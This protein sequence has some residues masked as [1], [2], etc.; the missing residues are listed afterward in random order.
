MKTNS[1]NFYFS[2][3]R[4]WKHINP[5]RRVQ[6][7][8]VFLLMLFASLAEVISIGAV[9]PFLGILTSPE[10]IFKHELAQPLIQALHL[11]EPS[12]L[13][14]PLTIVFTIAL[15]ISGVI[16][17]FLLWSQTRLGFAIGADLSFSIYHRTLYQPYA[18]HVSRNS[19][20]VITGISSRA[21]DV[22]SQVLMPILTIFSS[23]LMICMIL[24]ALMVI[25]PN[26]AIFGC[27]GFGIIYL[28]IIQI[29]KKRLSHDSKIISRE[30]NQVLKALQEGL[31]S[32]RDVL[33]DGTQ[34]IYCNIY[35]NSDLP[36][37]RAKAN[38]TIIGGSPRYGIETLGM[39]LI[40]I[41]AYTLAK[42]SGGL[43][44][45]AIPVLGAMALGAQR[46]LPVL[47]L[48][49]S[50]WATI[51]GAESSLRETLDI[52]DQPLPVYANQVL[53]EPISFQHEIS[54]NRLS[55]RYG[56]EGPWILRDLGLSI[57]KG[58]CVGFIG[59][60]GSGKSTLLD[61]I[62]GLLQ[63]VE[64]N[65]SIDGVIITSE[66]YRSWQ[67]RIAHVPQAIFLSDTTIAENIAFGIPK[68]NIDF[69]R[70]KVAA[71][72]AQLS[73]T[74][75]SL[76]KQY[77]TIV[78]E[79]G[80]RLSG[81]QR[82]RIGIARALYKKADVIVFDEATSALDNET[83]LN[84]MDAI[85]NLGDDL[86]IIIVA[87]RLTTLRNCNQVIELE[88][89]KVKRVATYDEVIKIN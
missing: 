6:F 78:G 24:S 59:V 80:V 77:N 15:I 48:T 76:D 45:T 66:N 14:L 1:R 53:P 3:G 60:T 49:F 17:L 55:F 56:N 13:L 23:I 12:Q 19:S 65:M 26:I 47:Q 61:I 25:N 70:V 40:V 67:L 88:A 31:G 83:E 5:K 8:F 50:G 69:D 39:I 46:M 84:V 10:R 54:I 30:S 9:F 42:N 43:S 33:L 68:E 7:G 86:T 21:N 41:L 27:I 63:P 44:S 18:V 89:G 85:E 11:T 73:E 2:L 82:Q 72:K 36:L 37:R 57:P 35:R 64:G 16:R 22:T 51:R 71:K 81:G 32:I 4:L 87:H 79:R 58:T 52:L 75:E 20:E 34:T 62:M 29:S 74:I 38:I 28:I